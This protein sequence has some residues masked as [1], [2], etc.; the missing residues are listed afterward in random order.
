MVF[1]PWF[2]G[3]INAGRTFGWKDATSLRMEDDEGEV[4]C[5][6]CTTATKRNQNRAPADALGAHKSPASKTVNLDEMFCVT[7]SWFET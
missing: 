3:G 5:T 4:L 7:K 2:D 1:A 6:G